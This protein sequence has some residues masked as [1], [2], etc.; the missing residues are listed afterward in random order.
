[1]DIRIV[2]RNLRS[3]SHLRVRLVR[4]THTARGRSTCRGRIRYHAARSAEHCWYRFLNR[5]GNVQ[6]AP[7]SCTR[8]SS[9][10]ISIPLAD[11]SACKQSLRELQRKMPATSAL[12]IRSA[13]GWRSR[14]RPDRRRSRIL[15][16]RRS[17]IYLRTEE[18]DCRFQISD[19]RFEAL[20]AKLA[21]Q[22]AI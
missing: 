14:P 4:T 11:S 3:P 10:R 15:L 13:Y 6:S 19:F 18:N 2:A 9:A 7:L 22:S 16:V 12:F 17:T 1:M 8:A 21:F 5:L 20:A